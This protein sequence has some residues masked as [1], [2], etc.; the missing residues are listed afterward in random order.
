MDVI[1][2]DQ[3]VEKVYSVNINLLKVNIETLEKRCVICWKVI[4]THQNDVLL[5]WSIF[6]TF[7]QYSHCSLQ[8]S[9]NVSWV[10]CQIFLYLLAFKSTNLSSNLTYFVE[11]SCFRTIVTASLS[12]KQKITFR[13]SFPATTFSSQ[14]SHK[15]NYN[16][17][18]CQELTI[19][20]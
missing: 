10:F 1:Q 6:L 2:K 18:Y 7:F 17:P 16:E 9:I 5:T 4:I 14:F 12:I 20:Y 8:T 15:H 13:F 11:S 3:T 19:I